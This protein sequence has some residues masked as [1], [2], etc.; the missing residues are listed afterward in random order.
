MRTNKNIVQHYNRNPETSRLL[1]GSGYIEGERTKSIIQRFLKGTHLEILDIGGA[2]GYYSFWLSASGHHVTLLDPSQ[3]Q[4]D[5]V[6]QENMKTHYPLKEI[7]LGEAQSLPFQEHIF[8]VAVNFGPMYHIQKSS[9][10]K[11]VLQEIKRVLK[12]N[13]L[14]F[15]AI[16]CR[17][18]SVI[19]G[20]RK[21]FILDP[22]YRKIMHKD[23]KTGIH[24][25]FNNDTY[26][27]DAYFHHPEEIIAELEENGIKN[28]RIFSLESFSWI[29][30][31][32]E[33]ILK[34]KEQK[35]ILF[36]ILEQIEE[37]KSMFGVSAHLLIVSQL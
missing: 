10:R 16:I 24:S 35:K 4:I 7:V 18:A 12:K 36:K 14:L 11:K 21:K 9:G 25:P 34:D 28:N 31:D 33:S 15:T 23:L 32:I 37:E 8:D 22:E 13:G 1:A 6:K 30:S 2:T 17:F 26:F 27:T 20:Y 29:I 5:I 19:D 3:I